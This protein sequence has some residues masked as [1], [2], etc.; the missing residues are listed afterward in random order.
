MYMIITAPSRA[1]TIAS[2]VL[3]KMQQVHFSTWKLANK[4]VDHLR[5]IWHL[6]SPRPEN[7]GDIIQLDKR[8]V[9]Y[10]RRAE[11]LMNEQ[12][13]LLL[14]WEAVCC[15][16]WMNDHMVETVCIRLF[17]NREQDIELHVHTITLHADNYGRR[18][19]QTLKHEK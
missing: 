13:T 7:N 10:S 9:N 18:T 15:N 14:G 6:L 17:M 8:H 1:E 2:E 3:T 11:N 5:T 4:A 19:T 12:I 16:K